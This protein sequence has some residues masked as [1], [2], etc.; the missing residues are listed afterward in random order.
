MTTITLRLLDMT[1][2]ELN[3]ILKDN[4]VRAN[5]QSLIGVWN[6]HYTTEGINGTYLHPREACVAV[7]LFGAKM[8]LSNFSYFL[9]D[10]C[11]TPLI[12]YVPGRN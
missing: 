4:K 3:K 10:S 5:P 6:N 8:K 12:V 1:L 2:Q 11:Y 9:N 7:K